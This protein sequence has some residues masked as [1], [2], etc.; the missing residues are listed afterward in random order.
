MS[1]ATHTRPDSKVQLWGS[2]IAMAIAVLFLLFDI[3]GKLARIA[4]VTESFARLGLPDHLA[5]TIGVLQLA[6][7]LV[8]M[9]PRTAVLGAV[10]LTGFLGG[11]IAIHVRIGDPLVTHVLFPVYI[12]TLLWGALYLRDARLRALIPLRR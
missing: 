1:S 8:Y 12:G 5:R 3:G 6:C 7:L 11:A 10:L 9:L 4:P 2:R